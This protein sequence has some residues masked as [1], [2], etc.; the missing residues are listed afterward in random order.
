M[1][2]SIAFG[3]WSNTTNLFYDSLHIPVCTAAKTQSAPLVVQSYPDSGYFVIWQDARN[4]PGSYGDIAGIYAQKY[5]KNGNQLWANNGVPVSASTNN[6]HYT[7]S[8]SDYRYHSFAATDSAGGFYISYA[9]DSVTN[10]VWQRAC[11]QHVLSSGNTVFPTGYILARATNANFVMMPQLIA[12]GNKGFFVS[13]RETL[14]TV[15][16]VCYKDVNGSLQYYGGGKMNENAVEVTASSACGNYEYLQ[17]PDA[18]VNDY[19]IFSDLQGGCNIAMDLH[20]NGSQGPMIAYN[21]LWR[22]KKNAT[23]TE[24]QFDLDYSLKTINTSY[25]KDNVYRLYYLRTN[26]QEIRCGGSGNVYVVNQYRLTQLGYQVLDGGSSVYDVSNCKGTAV[27]TAGNI[28]VSLLAACKRSYSS[29]TGVSNAVVRGYNIKEEIYDSIP[30][31]RASCNDAGYPGYNTTEPA[32]INKLNYFRDTLLAQGVSTYDFCLGGGA[33]QIF[34]SALMADPATYATFNLALRLQHLAVERQSADS[35]AVVYKTSKKIGEL[36]GKDQGDIRYGTEFGNP[37]VTVDKSGI[38]FFY[39]KDSYDQGARVSPIFYGAQLAWGALGRQIGTGVYNASYYNVSSPAAALDPLNG[40]GLIAW[41][42]DRNASSSGS[43]VLMRHLDSLNLTNYYPPVKRIRLI[44]NPYT[45]SS[46]LPAVLYGVSKRYTLL[47]TYAPYGNDAGITPVAEIKDD[48][49]L[50][51]TT[52]R[53]YQNTGGI[54]KYNGK[55]YLDRNFTIYADSVP[56]HSNFNIRLYF[57]KIEFNALK[58]NDNSITTPA[59]LIVI[60]Q[61]HNSASYPST[62]APVANEELLTPVAWDSVTGGYYVEVR[63]NSL[64]D[65]FIQ[66]ASISSVCPGGSTSITSN[67]TGSSYQWKVNTGAGFVNITNNTNYTGATSVTLQLNNIPSSWAGYQYLCVVNGTNSNVTTL[68]FINTWSGTM[69][70]YW[71]NT[72]NWSC[73]SVPD[74]NTDVI[75]NS[76]TIVVNSNASCRT[77]TINPGATFT[78]NAGY[79]L[80][81]TY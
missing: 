79:K 37:A 55:A 41:S 20:G 54:R 77:L 74:A 63:A 53:V 29:A 4:D 44:P 26:H 31:Q 60:K 36:I 69:N 40:K 6:Q 61:P 56:P 35:F 50:G 47:E 22:A 39:I 72:A 64:G 65:F 16:I 8:G 76:G 59:D 27:S 13:F 30:Y 75:L 78:V 46:S 45:A 68:H 43:D 23:S 52:A 10:Y 15:D 1:N 58:A 38:G 67:I 11:V 17:Y 80:T 32:G 21:K 7:N 34:A 62:Y 48:N 51:L 14:G 18:E 42:D 49:Y 25:Q 3:Q 9:D 19:N 57:T 71:D 70:N 66:K 73:G 33:N 12:D 24:T 28:N 5:D 81:V 2:A